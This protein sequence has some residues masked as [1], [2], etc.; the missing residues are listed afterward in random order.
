MAIYHFSGTVI[1][2]RQG[3]SA[4]ACAAYRSAEKLYDERLNKTYDYT[5]KQD[6]AHTEI[7]LPEGAPSFLKERNKLWNAVEASEKRKDAQLA[8]EFNFSLPKELTLEQNIALAREFVQNEF[9]SRG[10]VADLCVHNDLTPEGELQPHAHVMLTMRE[11]KTNGTPDDPFGQKVREWNDKALLM[12]WRESWAEHANRALAINGHDMQIDHRTLKEQGI[13]LE[14]QH[15]I[16][17]AVVRNRKARFE[18]HQRIAHENGDKILKDPR[19][20]LDAL[21]KQQSTFTYEDVAK[22]INRH[23]D[24]T[25]QFQE[26]YTKVMASPELHLLG[27]DDKN[28]ERYTTKTL[29]AIE[30]KMI[31]QAVDLNKQKG[32][33]VADRNQDYALSTKT[34]TDE[35]KAA[36]NYITGEGNIKCVVGYAGTGKSYMLGAAREA[37]EAQGYRVHGGAL[38]GIAAESLEGSSGI[39]SRTLASRAWYWDRDR[40]KL[41]SKDI[42]IIDEAG[43]I[44]SRQ[45]GRLLDEV[46]AAGAKIVLV[47]DNEQ[48]QAIDAGAAYRAICEKVGYVELA[49]VRRQQHE[50]QKQAT[51][52]FALGRTQSAMNAYEHFNHI[53]EFVSEAE[54]KANIVE[55]WNDVRHSE[56][57]KSQ[58]ILAY[59]RAEVRSFNELARQI[60]KADHELGKDHKI[61]TF[62]GE[63]DFAEGDRIYFLK[64]ERSLGVKNGTLGTIEEIK[65]NEI[66]VRLDRKDER[67]VNE[68]VKVNPDFYNYLDHGY[69]ATVHKA[70]AVTVDRTYVLGSN[71][72]DRHATYVAMTRHRDSADFFYSQEKF[73]NKQ[74][75][76]ASISRQNAK[77]VSLD[78]VDRT[79]EFAERRGIEKPDRQITMEEFKQTQKEQQ[80]LRSHDGHLDQFEDY[81]TRLKERY[82][83]RA[84]EHISKKLETPQNRQE[85]VIHEQPLSY[86]EKLRAKMQGKESKFDQQLRQQDPLEKLAKSYADRIG[87]LEKNISDGKDVIN[88][89]REL[90]DITQGLAK[91]ED[92]IKYYED[93][94]PSMA[95]SI[96]RHNHEYT[97]RKELGIEL[98]QRRSR[99]L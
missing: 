92:I 7:M 41:T 58:I 32:H 24:T 96:E 50:W 22:F 51:V 1:S 30:N 53:H 25:E 2:R 69:S 90:Y 35:Q 83:Q 6:V 47:G 48:L 82:Q 57:D 60:R 31:D 38:S 15:K 65:N 73:D 23:T 62:R 66:T 12:Q 77:D 3:R 76:I 49:E 36:F 39:E 27:K 28:R 99:S 61:M 46:H 85:Q 11:V 59:T 67:G 34:L 78:Y 43:M 18:D 4:V 91:R 64:N 13:D 88:N 29:Y 33:A 56:P 19:I 68:V 40:E 63:R 98:G 89:R 94:M 71:Y 26:V 55:M 10:M 8:R 42:L 93:K 81:E 86:E 45:M 95:N 21:T 9:V 84:E 72:M 14:P 44:G 5:N 87:E 52:D 70:Q 20:A 79:V 16:G 75:M 54:A 74:S 80:H 37:W 97:H 17:A